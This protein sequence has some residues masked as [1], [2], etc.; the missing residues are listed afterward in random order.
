MK[1]I[2]I[3]LIEDFEIKKETLERINKE[4][5]EKIAIL[6][7]IQ[8]EKVA[9]ELIKQLKG[10]KIT[11]FSQTLGCANPKIP[12]D[13]SA[14]LLIGESEFH[15]NSLAY[16]SKKEVYVLEKNILKKVEKSEIEKLEKKEKIAYLNFLNNDEIG[17]LITTKPGQARL[18][19]ALE[20]KNQIKNKKIY[21]FLANEVQTKEFENF[22]LKSWINTA[23]PRIDLEDNRII[24]MNVVSKYLNL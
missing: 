10:K 22:G 19:R 4:L 21:F 9:K 12:K 14:I 18:S 24:N 7:I 20:L 3:P 1:K 16:E 2:F 13:T 8:Y 17:V 6:Y 15:S 5:P 23:C 11:K